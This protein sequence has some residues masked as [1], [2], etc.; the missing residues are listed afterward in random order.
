MLINMIF[1]KLVERGMVNARVAQ[2]VKMAL[3][4]LS[5]SV[6]CSAIGLT[7]MYNFSL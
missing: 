3:S 5:I 1:D 4:T 7:L 2:S 6:L